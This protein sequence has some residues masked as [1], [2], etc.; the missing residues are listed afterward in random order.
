[1][2]F[3]IAEHSLLTASVMMIGEN[4]IFKSSFHD[5]T[6]GANGNLFDIIQIIKTLDRILLSMG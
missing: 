4:Y 2:A 3:K 6:G 1:M 5:H